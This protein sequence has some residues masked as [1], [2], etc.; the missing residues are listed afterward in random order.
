MI[1]FIVS[2]I[3]LVI[4]YFTY[5]K[6]IDKM[7]GTKEERPTPAYH[8]RDNVDYLPMKTSSNSLI[9]LLNIAGVGPIF[10]P[11]MGALYGPVAFIW[12]VVGCI[13]AGA[14]HDYLTGMI[15]IRNKGAHLPELAGKFLGQVMKHFVNI[16]SILLLLL[17]GTV[18]VTSPALL[19]HNLLDGRIALGI[20]IF[21][22]FWIIL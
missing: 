18:F 19:L 11:I 6:Y 7:F 21:V 4:G 17:T 13:F 12:I 16:F 1:T 5:G 2:I 15:S 10:G 8:Q 3:L 22:I 20:I 9:Q 14:V